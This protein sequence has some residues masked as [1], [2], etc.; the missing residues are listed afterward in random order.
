MVHPAHLD[1]VIAALQYLQAKYKFADNYVLV[2]HSCG[3]TLA[4]Q[5]PNS[6]RLVPPAGIIGVEGIYDLGR[7][8]DRHRD[9]PMYQ[10]FIESAFGKNEDAWKVASPTT[11]GSR[12]GFLWEGPRVVALAQSDGDELVD[13]SQG[14]LMWET[15]QLRR[16]EVGNVSIRLTGKHDE[17][18]REGE[19]ETQL[20]VAIVKVL[21]S[22]IL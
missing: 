17:I 19:R 22:L 12:D 3:A 4:F 16:A 5:I 8:R 15:V 2:G 9:V 18:W 6:A 20:K 21:E 11:Q 13:V 7:L 14:D 1:D 10:Y